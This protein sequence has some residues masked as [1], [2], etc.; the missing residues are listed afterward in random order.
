MKVLVFVDDCG[1][2]SVYDIDKNHGRNAINAIVKDDCCDNFISHI[3]DYYEVDE[4]NPDCSLLGT[5]VKDGMLDKRHLKTLDD[6]SL[7]Y[8]WDTV[9]NFGR[10]QP[11]QIVEVL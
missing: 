10:Y 9:E 6:N 2:T 3:Y 5:L 7:T 8:L 1:H 4:E 11:F